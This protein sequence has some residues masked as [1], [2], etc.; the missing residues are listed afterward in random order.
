M[1]RLTDAT[2]PVNLSNVRPRPWLIDHWPGISASSGTAV[3]PHI[4]VGKALYEDIH[5]A[6]P[7]SY[8][9]GLIIHEQE[10]IKRIRPYG[11]VRWYLRYLLWPSFRLEE[12]LAAYGR[13]FEY[14]KSLGLTYD[15]D[16][17][18]RR[19]AGFVYLWS[20]SRR[21]AL[22]RLRRLWESA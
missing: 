12:E 13:Q 22:T 10:H 16:R 1:T 9:I 21:Q 5:S 18:A 19:L 14:L 2:S 3:Y 20:T 4:Y 11:P 17:C 15:L 8:H 7:D 6:S